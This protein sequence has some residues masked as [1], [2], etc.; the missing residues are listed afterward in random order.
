MILVGVLSLLLAWPVPAQV[1]K[2]KA[3]HHGMILMT[4]EPVDISDFDIKVMAE[5]PA[6][7]KLRQALDLIY[8]S[9]EFSRKKLSF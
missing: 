6:L 8:T 2:Q 9:S 4:V 5:A 1:A 7:K 3:R